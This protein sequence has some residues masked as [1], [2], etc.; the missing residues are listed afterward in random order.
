MAFVKLSYLIASICVVNFCP[1]HDS[2]SVKKVHKQ[3]SEIWPS[4][5]AKVLCLFCVVTGA[6]TGS[7]LD[8]VLKNLMHILKQNLTVQNLF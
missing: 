8:S 7:P 2:F 4:T 5:S 1:G 6:G 3:A